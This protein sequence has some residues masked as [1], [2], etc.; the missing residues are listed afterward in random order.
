MDIYRNIIYSLYGNH[1]G[2]LM[3]KEKRQK[4]RRKEQRPSN[5]NLH[6]SKNVLIHTNQNALAESTKGRKIRYCQ[7]IFCK[8]KIRSNTHLYKRE[9]AQQGG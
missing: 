8:E 5:E 2:V 7:N 6:A 9:L 4:R 3:K 1:F